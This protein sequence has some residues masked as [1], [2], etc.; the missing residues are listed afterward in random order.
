MAQTKLTQVEPDPRPD[1][2]QAGASVLVVDDEPGMR[3]F[4]AKT[5]GPRVARLE[6]AASP[7]EATRK[8]DD[9]FFDII[10]LDNIMTGKTGLE[11]V[12]EQKRRGLFA[13]VV[14]ITAYAV[15]R[16]A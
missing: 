9:A 8:L 2:K 4:L 7:A 5:L 14:M 10:I 11:W 12:A 15:S 1:T 13:D 3:N 16:S 6:E